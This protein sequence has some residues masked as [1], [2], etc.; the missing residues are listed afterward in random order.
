MSDEAIEL[1][2]RD[3]DRFIKGLKDAELPSCK[4]G[5]MGDKAMR[6]ANTGEP[7]VTNA[8]IGARHEYGI[9]VP[10]RSFLRTPISDNLANYLKKSG[11]LDED[12]MKEVV[13]TGAVT[14]WLKK[15]AVVG[16]SIVA[17]AFS[18][19]GFGKWQPWAPGYVNNTGQILVD[20]QQLRNSITSVVKE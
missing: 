17:D 9:G 20:T 11:A 12:V 4:I 13:K 8:D 15:V 2:T 7:G 18:S 16:E 5:I 14:P 10:Q 6:K 3:L 1:N 19:N